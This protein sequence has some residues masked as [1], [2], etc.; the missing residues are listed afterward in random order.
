M[1]RKTI[2]DHLAPAP[3]AV[4][5]RMLEARETL[6]PGAAAVVG[7]F[8]K[9][10][11]QRRESFD[12][13][14]QALFR[15]VAKSES[16]L[17]TLLRAL[18]TYAP[19][20]ATT[21]GRSLRREWYQ[22]RP[23]PEVISARS[24]KPLTA[25]PNGPATWPIDWQLMFVGLQA[26]PRIKASSLKRYVASINRCAAAL[27]MTEADGTL[28]FYTGYCLAE[29]F[30]DQ[31]IKHRTIAGYLGGLVSLGKYGQAPEKAL[32]GLRVVVQYHLDLGEMEEKNK[33]ERLRKLMEKGG[34]DHVAAITGQLR[35]EIADMPAHAARTQLLRQTVA[36]LAVHINK[37]VRTG[38]AANWVL[39]R[40]L[41]RHPDGVWE[42]E[43]SQEKTMVETGAGRLWDEVSEILDELLLDGRPDRLIHLIYEQMQGLNWL[44]HTA[45]PADRRVPR[46]R[47]KSAIGVPSHDLRT[48]AADYL[49]RA[50]PA[51]APGIIQT[52]L[53]HSTLK[54]GESYRLLCASD[55]AAQDWLAIKRDIAN[56]C[57]SA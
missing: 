45:A 53:G 33:E 46:E 31:G 41:I 27:M 26:A 50:D 40:D 37:P 54:A 28:N 8:F 18:T 2:Q 51:R 1:T 47:I 5:R 25:G 57:L 36:L 16:T 19:E 11:T 9:A 21:A 39:G 48:L 17:A 29:Q 22:K 56:G 44:M 43:W 4:R 24:A 30:R 49:R 14:S 10:L 55:V 15:T 12:N 20:V 7:R 6:E 3:A 42:L 35:D 32:N 38:D 52:H 13:P 23:K 34:Y